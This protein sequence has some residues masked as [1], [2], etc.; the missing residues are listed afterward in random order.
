[1]ESKHEFDAFNREFQSVMGVLERHL[2]EH[3]AE[4]I[5]KK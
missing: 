5:V 3:E 1:M 4:Y 2:K